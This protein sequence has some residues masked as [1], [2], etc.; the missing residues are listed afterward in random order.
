MKTR[1][2]LSALSFLYIARRIAVSTGR[3]AFATTFTLALFAAAVRPAYSQT[4]SVIYSFTGLP[5]G[6]APFAGLVMDTKGNFYST[7]GFGG[8]SGDGTVFRVSATGKEKVLFS[9]MRDPEG[10]EP[11]DPLIIDSKGNLYGTTPL[12][13]ANNGSGTAFVI[14]PAGAHKILYNFTGG[15]DGGDPAAAL[16]MD[17][18]GILYGTTSL[19]GTS[20]DGTVFSLTPAGKEK[21][22]Y[23]FMGGLD[24][25]NPSSSLV[26]DA[27]GNLYGSEPDGGNHVAGTIFEVT[28][29]GKKK[30]LYAFAGEPDG[31]GPQS[32][33]IRD[34]KGNLYGATSGGGI[35]NCGGGCGVIFK[36]SPSGAETVLYSFTGGADG[37][38]P[39]GSLFRDAKGNLYGTTYGGG[40]SS[41]GTVFKLTPTGTHSVLYNFT[42]GAD[43]GNPSPGLIQDAKGNFYG[44]AQS[45]GVG[46]GVVFKITP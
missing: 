16:V 43:G 10:A 12:G 33:L 2:P 36:V 18:K 22:L 27:N 4:E 35:A 24:G 38:L 26:I 9:F 3:C 5:D 28:P 31:D 40:T 17:S 30:V 14:S 23:S 45:G 15:A 8:A 11:R 1:P 25:R 37:Q 44:T 42:G 46:S 41:F 13:G 20:G 34:D 7:T 32:G 39:N 21:V 19:G 29:A 6:E